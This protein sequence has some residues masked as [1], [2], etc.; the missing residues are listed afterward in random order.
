MEPRFQ[1]GDALGG[2]AYEGSAITQFALGKDCILE[3]KD[4]QKICR[5]LMA[6]ERAGSYHAFC[7]NPGKL[8]PLFDLTVTRAAPITRIWRAD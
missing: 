2:P 7:I 6:G 4:Q 1:A 3:L 8:T 5:R